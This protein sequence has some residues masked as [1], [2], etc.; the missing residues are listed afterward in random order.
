MKIEI[1]Y[2]LYSEQ[3]L[4]VEDV[5]EHTTVLQALNQSK[6]LQRFPDLDIEKVGIFGKVVKHDQRLRE[7]D[8]IEIYRPL[9]ADPKDRRRERVAKEREQNTNQKKR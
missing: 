3:Y 7:G 1:A 4:D 2:A 9:K 8:R 5:V 6:M